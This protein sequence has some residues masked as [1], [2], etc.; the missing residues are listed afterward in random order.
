M[1]ASNTVYIL[2]GLLVLWTILLSIFLVRLMTHYQSL[3][4]G[5]SQ[6]D[7]ISA[8]NNFIAKTAANQEAIESVKDHL[9]KE[10]TANQLHLQ[11]VGF[12]RFNPFTDTGGN[13]SFI[14]SLLDENGTGVVISSLHSRENTR[15]YAKAIDKGQCQ[16]QIL[17]KEERQVIRD[18]LK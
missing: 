5:L 12:L 15:V 7:L 17:S 1:S 8:L 6:K 16:D 9:A 4:R 18:S 11:K 14:L 13:Q 3:T 2:L 10:V